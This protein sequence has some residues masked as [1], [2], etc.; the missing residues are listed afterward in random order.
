MTTSHAADPTR[1]KMAR[2]IVALMLR[3]MSSTYGR[4][5]GGYIWALIEPISGIAFLTVVFSYALRSPSIGDSFALYY[6]TGMLPLGLFRQLSSKTAGAIRYS[7]PLLGYPRV[8]FIDTIL[9]RVILNSFTHILISAMLIGGMVL[10][11][12]SFVF[13]N[14]P[15]IGLAFIMS[16]SLGVGIGTLNC[17]LFWRVDWWQP[18]WKVLMRPLFIISGVLYNFDDLPA[19]AQDILWWNPIVHVVGQMRMGVFATYEPTYISY[20]FVFSISLVTL[21]AGLTLLSR[22]H[23]DIL[24]K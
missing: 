21:S 3:E 20:I 7:K 2:T 16:I 11:S 4:S 19:F 14:M 12:P 5:T 17:F 6:A 13:L 15:E 24:Y 18:L 23:D 22:F 8:T 9:A 1:F 10:I